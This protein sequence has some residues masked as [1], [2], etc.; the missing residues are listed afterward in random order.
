MIEK[1]EELEINFPNSQNV[2]PKMK[3]RPFNSINLN[4]NFSCCYQI[5]DH[6]LFFFQVIKNY[7]F[8]SHNNSSTNANKNSTNSSSDDE[9]FIRYGSKSAANNA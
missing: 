5:T 8:A 4:Q 9:K 1:I 6:F 7:L 2:M 3:N